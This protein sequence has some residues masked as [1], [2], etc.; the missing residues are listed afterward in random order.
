MFRAPWENKA[1]KGNWENAN[2]WERRFSGKDAEADKAEVKA[3][4]LAREA[5]NAAADAEKGEAAK[6]AAN[7]RASQAAARKASQVAQYQKD[8]DQEAA[9]AAA[10][11][12]AEAAAAAAAAAEAEKGAKAVKEQAANDATT[13]IQQDAGRALSS[14]KRMDK[15]TF[16]FKEV[17]AGNNIPTDAGALKKSIALAPEQQAIVYMDDEEG[18]YTIFLSTMK[19]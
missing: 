17:N 3:Y 1:D 11:Q 6:A 9:A 8:R 19:T 16:V 4:Q 15:R 5:N 10:K 7:E 2:E 14:V 18:E 13:L 12:A